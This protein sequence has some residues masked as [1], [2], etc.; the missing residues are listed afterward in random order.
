MI[1]VAKSAAVKAGNFLMSNFG[2]IG[3][4]IIKG[5][6]DLVTNVDREAEK[7]VADILKKEF[8][9]HGIIGE[10]NEKNPKSSDY[11]WIIDPLDG[12]HNF[13]RGMS[14]FGVSI[15]LW[16]KD[17]FILGVVYMPYNDELYYAQK[18][19]GAF[20]NKERISVSEVSD[21]R[22]AS[23][24]F[25]SSIR[26]SPEVMLKTLGVVS[27]ECFNIRMLGSS[28]RLLTY[29]A[30]GTLD[31]AIEF[32]DHPWDFAGTVCIIKE[33]GGFFQDLNGNRPTPETIGYFTGNK[34]IYSQLKELLGKCI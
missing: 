22:K 33:A 18:G 24:S 2:R 26:Y 6:R 15:G 31:F 32:H 9:S 21:I 20:K 28:A 8:P 17:E 19:K 14:V 30:E 25:D 23:C 7:I 13:I 4:V 10:E 3:E 34:N 12:T 1:E 11:L 16:H 5:D 27:R 29:V